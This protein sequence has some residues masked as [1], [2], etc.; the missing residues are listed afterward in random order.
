MQ[1]FQVALWR[2]TEKKVSF[3]VRIA[4]LW[5]WH[6][7]HVSTLW[8]SPFYMP[9]CYLLVSGKTDNHDPRMYTYIYTLSCFFVVHDLRLSSRR[10]FL[11][12]KAV[13]ETTLYSKYVGTDHFEPLLK[14]YTGSN[15]YNDESIFFN[16]TL[17]DLNDVHWSIG[18]EF[19]ITFVSTPQVR[20]L[21]S[22]SRINL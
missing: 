13:Y 11:T 21:T 14:L 7:P 10:L 1:Q 16:K 4:Y 5:H 3:T 18:T 19:M 17:R 22:Y 20:Y 12:T 15:S 8:F 9:E 6:S 2:R